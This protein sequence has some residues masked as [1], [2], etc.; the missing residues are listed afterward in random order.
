[1]FKW[2][3]ALPVFLIALHGAPVASY[4]VGE[5]IGPVLMNPGSTICDTAEDAILAIQA[6][7]GASVGY[8]ASCGRLTAPLPVLMEIIDHFKS[9][10]VVYAILKVGFLPPARLGIQYGWTVDRQTDQGHRVEAHDPSGD[11]T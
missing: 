7:D 2:I 6:L 1:M 10:E 8:P 4:E 5:R 3:L 11:H 9:G